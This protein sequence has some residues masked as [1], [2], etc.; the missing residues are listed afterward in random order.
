VGI[1]QTL[2]SEPRRRGLGLREPV[3]GF[4]EVVN[5]AGGGT[6][7]E[8]VRSQVGHYIGASEA[9]EGKPPLMASPHLGGWMVLPAPVEQRP[10]FPVALIAESLPV[11]AQG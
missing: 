3:E 11:E 6:G 9:V 8:P 1:V 2:V 5:P 10:R 4:A 7:S